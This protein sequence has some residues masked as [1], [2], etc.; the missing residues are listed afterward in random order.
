MNVKYKVLICLGSG[1]RCA[2]R[3][4]GFLEHVRKQ[5][6]PITKDG[7]KQGK[8]YIQAFPHDYTSSTIAL[9]ANRLALQPVIPIIDRFQ[10]R[11]CLDHYSTSCKMMKVYRNKEHL[12][13]DVANNELF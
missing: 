7:R 11:H 9:P 3:P 13:K 12:L 4:S 1:C 6:H 2:V 5:K 10:C 8:E